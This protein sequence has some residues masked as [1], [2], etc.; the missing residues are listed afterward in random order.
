MAI[1]PGAIAPVADGEGVIGVSG[2]GAGTT[3][4]GVKGIGAGIGYGVKG[5]GT[6]SG[7]GV[8]GFGLLSGLAGLFQSTA[9]ATEA[10]AV[11]DSLTTVRTDGYIHVNSNNPAHNAVGIGPNRL[12]AKNVCKTWG[13]ITTN[14]TSVATIENGF[15]ISTALMDAF[16]YTNIVI[17][18]QEPMTS[19]WYAV[20]TTMGAGQPGYTVQYTATGLTGFSLQLFNPAGASAPWDPFSS[21][22]SFVV[23]G[24]Q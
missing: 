6:A 22:F 3:G 4:V 8:T 2:T 13:A 12:T 21:T 5:I 7:S 16:P 10:S 9:G 23:F 14:G 19:I 18:F 15:N 1:G 24:V 17:T 11:V 20:V